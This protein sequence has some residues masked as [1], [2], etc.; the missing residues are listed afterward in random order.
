MYRLTL[1]R[2][3][4]AS[5]AAAVFALVSCAKV[6]LYSELDEAEANEVMATLLQ[7]NLPCTKVP[8]KEGKWILQVSPE[9]FP[10]AM[11]TLN[12]VGL[13][14]EKHQKMGE[15]F[16]KSGLISSPTEER[17]RYISALSQEISDTLMQ[18]DGV[19]SARV[20]VALPENDPLAEETKPPSAAVFIKYRAGYDLESSMPDL[21][22]LVTKSIEGL[23]FDNVEIVMTQGT[24]VEPPPKME[25]PNWM[26][27]LPKWAVP[28]GSAV[29]GAL[30]MILL[31]S[32]FRKRID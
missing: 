13:P 27:R 32:L 9:D 12:S 31:I 25:S 2:L 17:I 16:Q 6:P 24:L 8:G 5:L 30:F 19:L 22:N 15:V 21:K 10:L 18:I 28:T 14:R 11:S 29:G 1:R 23:S 26:D 4:Q 7:K 3:G 20:H